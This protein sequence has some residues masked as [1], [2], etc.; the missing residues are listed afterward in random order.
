MLLLQDWP[1]CLGCPNWQQ[2][3]L[4]G[5]VSPGSG[6]AT[7]SQLSSTLAVLQI[8]SASCLMCS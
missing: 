8:L 6:E 7:S 2:L 1:F 3:I 4:M 5:R